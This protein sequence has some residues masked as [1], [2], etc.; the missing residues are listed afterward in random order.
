MVPGFSDDDDPPTA[1][2]NNRALEPSPPAT[3]LIDVDAMAPH[4]S[5]TFSDA[6]MMHVPLD[7]EAEQSLGE[8]GG[9]KGTSPNL[10]DFD[11]DRATPVG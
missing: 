11:S 2:V 5:R 4:H 1:D 10:I 9:R 7:E 3:A 6:S 8:Q